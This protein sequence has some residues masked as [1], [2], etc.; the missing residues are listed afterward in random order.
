M[1]KNMET[2][3]ENR[4]KDIIKY[5]KN[6]KNSIFTIKDEE[7]FLTN[8]DKYIYLP[9]IYSVFEIP[10]L[11][12]EVLSKC[13]I[14]SEHHLNENSEWE[15]YRG[16][17]LRLSLSLPDDYFNN[18]LKKYLNRYEDWYKSRIL[19]PEYIKLIQIGSPVAICKSTKDFNK[20][21]NK[22]ENIKFDVT[23]M[24]DDVYTEYTIKAYSP[25]IVTDE[26]FLDSDVV[27]R[28]KIHLNRELRI[29]Y[30]H[31]LNSYIQRAGIGREIIRQLICL[32]KKEN[33]H[34]LVGEIA[35]SALGFY[36]KLNDLGVK[37]IPNDGLY[38]NT[39]EI[40]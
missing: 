14:I 5:T 38:K 35:F 17:K 4:L 23:E 36:K 2:T 29:G 26:N 10:K 40:I 6:R 24:I 25:D 28:V 32:K 18:T 8:Y 37:V 31:S 12:V 20:K 16:F 15:G 7:D 19:H 30:V 21:Q 33:I 22:I 1:N 13:I 34:K 27:G 3:I 9:P 39:F 11:E